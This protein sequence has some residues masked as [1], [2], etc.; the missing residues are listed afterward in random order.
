MKKQISIIIPCY[1]SSETIDTCMQSLLSQTIGIHNLEII[2][3]NDASTDNTLYKLSHWENSYPDT[4]VVINCTE[5]GGPGQ[6][7]NIG[8]QYASAD[9][10]GFIDDDDYCEPDMYETLYTATTTYQCDLVICKSVRQSNNY[11]P[12]DRSHESSQGEL[13]VLQ[14][15]AQRL[16][17]LERDIND[18]VWNKLYR[19]TML[20]DNQIAFPTDVYYEDILFTCLVKLYCNSVFITEKT[21]YHHITNASSISNNV[22][23]ERRINLMEVLIMLFDELQSRGFYTRFTFWCEKYF[24]VNYLGFITNY[25][26]L[27]GKMNPKFIQIISQSVHALFPNFAQI[28]LVQLLLQDSSHPKCQR[29]L[30]ELIDSMER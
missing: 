19:R 1:N 11:Q 5:N 26:E 9:Y 24:I 14:N 17:F 21:L 10:I 4:V 2:C 18:A 30:G 8:I 25:E 6:A 16:A 23:P 29:I 28:P 20:T 27:F 7:R 13:I 12:I 3:V 22:A 15:D